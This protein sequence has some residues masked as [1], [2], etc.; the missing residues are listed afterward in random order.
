MLIQEFGKDAADILDTDGITI[1][2]N[3]EHNTVNGKAEHFY[4]Y[5]KELVEKMASV[6]DDE[7]VY[8]KTVI[9]KLLGNKITP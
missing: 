4:N 9:E 2:V 5:P 3:A 8:L 6:K 7:I 1:N